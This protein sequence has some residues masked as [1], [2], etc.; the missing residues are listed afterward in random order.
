MRYFCEKSARP[1]LLYSLYA[2]ESLSGNQNEMPFQ[3]FVSSS[4]FFLITFFFTSEIL[5]CKFAY[6]FTFKMQLKDFDLNA[7]TIKHAFFVLYT[8]L[9]LACVQLPALPEKKSIFFLRR[10]G[11]CTQAMLYSD[12]S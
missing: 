9:Y 2:T 10:A 3:S 12:V 1:R 4:F 8:P 11:G 6:N 5:Y 7:K